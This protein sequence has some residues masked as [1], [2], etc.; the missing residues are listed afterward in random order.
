MH[1]QDLWDSSNEKQKRPNGR[2]H[3]SAKLLYNSHYVEPA[4]GIEPATF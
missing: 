3:Y 2:L 4:A 1:G